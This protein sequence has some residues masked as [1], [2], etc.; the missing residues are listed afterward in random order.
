MLDPVNVVMAVH[1]G[2]SCTDPLTRGRRERSYRVKL[3]ACSSLRP[4]PMNPDV[5]GR[6]GVDTSSNAA[7]RS[8]PLLAGLGLLTL[9]GW[10]V[11]APLGVAVACPLKSLTG[12]ECAFCGATRATLA[13]L[14]GHVG[15]A[16]NLNLV[17]TVLV[18][19]AFA[20]A[21]AVGAG[22][23]RWRARIVVAYHRLDRRREALQIAAALLAVWTVTRN[24]PA[25]H[26]LAAG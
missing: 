6:K 19:P 5:P 21:L 9:A 17:Y 13:L 12:Y 18:L 3:D 10:L 15:R 8:G 14:G 2:R 24:V 11:S 20:L 16:I 4:Y 26:W 23:A 7:V 1:T 25:L 22:P